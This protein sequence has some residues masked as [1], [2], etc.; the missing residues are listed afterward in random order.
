MDY[1]EEVR[2]LKGVTVTKLSQEAGVHRD[3][4]YKWIR[5]ERKPKFESVAKMCK[6]LDIPIEIFVEKFLQESE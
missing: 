2:K 4:Y 3:T 5:K 1:I 6:V